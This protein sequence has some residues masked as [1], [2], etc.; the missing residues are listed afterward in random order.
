MLDFNN[1]NNTNTNNNIN[2][3]N[4]T[5]NTQDNVYNVKCLLQYQQEFLYIVPRYC[6]AVNYLSYLELRRLLWHLT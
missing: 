4:N 6:S 3:K 2:D 5:N 1:N